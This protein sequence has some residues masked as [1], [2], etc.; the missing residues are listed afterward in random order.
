MGVVENEQLA[1]AMERAGLNQGELAEAV[2]SQLDAAGLKPSVTD[3]TVRYWLA[4]KTRWPQKAIRRALVAVFGCH[5][6]DLG[7]VPPPP[8]GRAA[9]VPPEDS[10]L[11][12]RTFLTAVG[13]AAAVAPLP[14][15]PRRIGMGDVERLHQRFAEIIAQDH[16]QGGSRDAENQALAM[17]GQALALQSQ[18]SASQRVRAALYATA[19]AFTSSAMWAAIDAR[20]FNE[21]QTYF[22]QAAALARMSNEQAIEFRIWSHAG[23][24]FRHLNRSSDALAANDVARGMAVTRKDPLFASLGHARHAAILGLTGDRP[25]V[26]RA[27]GAAQDAFGRAREESRPVWLTAFFDQAE[28]HSLAVAAY[29]SLRDF[30]QAEA[31]AHSSLTHLR[32]HLSRSRA[33]TTAR[34][35]RAQAGQ[36][37]F[38]TA[39]T[40]AAPLLESGAGQHPRVGQMLT[41]LARGMQESAP[42]SPVAREWADRVRDHLGRTA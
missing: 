12:R 30:E 25:A 28:L 22:N 39:V 15:A 32:G 3:R 33:I 17:A 27:M 24:M 36:G 23:S 9:V 16:Q 19:A 40:T 13:T 42:H 4:G 38:E 26:E 7:F 6:E 37:E 10:A 31:H 11:L 20:R 14:P 8:R 41:R 34:L 2:N 21:A 5:I 35:A 1:A 18:G 29:L